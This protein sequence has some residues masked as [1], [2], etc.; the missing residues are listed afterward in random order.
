MPSQASRSGAGNRPT[1]PASRIVLVTADNDTADDAGD[2]QRLSAPAR[3]R[4]LVSI[5]P[6]TRTLHQ[7]GADLLRGL[8]KRVET[9]GGSTTANEIWFRACAWIAGEQIAEIVVS[10]AHLLSRLRLERLFEIAAIA[11]TRLWLVFQQPALNRGQRETVRDW[12]LPTIDFRS[13][14]KLCKPPGDHPS[15]QGHQDGF[16]EVPDEEFPTFLS[17]CEELLRPRDFELVRER[18]W[19][20]YEDT[21]S[22]IRSKGKERPRRLLADLGHLL[23]ECQSLSRM[24]VCARAAQAAALHCG[25][26]I[27]VNSTVLAGAHASTRLTTLDDVAAW[28]LRCYS[29]PRYPAAAVLGLATRLPPSRLAALDVGD[30]DPDGTQ[31]DVGQWAPIPAPGQGIVRAHLMFRHCEG[32]APDHPLFVSEKRRAS[33]RAGREFGR[34]TSHG[35]H[36]ALRRVA[37]ETGLSV[38][39]VE[40]GGDAK[41]RMARHGI[42]I[43][44][45]KA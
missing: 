18:Y 24:V 40:D 13:F 29:Q 1:I 22:A 3:G 38:V 45:L 41:R 44:E 19:S 37:L 21:L 35:L 20:A 2:L 4:L 11:G 6:D 5:R 30:V 12:D 43:H 32:S 39:P 36:Q 31:V 23:A 26:L 25:Y 27:K 9:S 28:K 34:I 7:L 14:K 16:P 33:G 42:T 15:D 8:G 17:A 10:R